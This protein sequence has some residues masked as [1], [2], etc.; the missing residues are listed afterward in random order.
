MY[1][2]SLNE[3]IQ[4]QSNFPTIHM[5]AKGFFKTKLIHL[6]EMNVKYEN[7]LEFVDMD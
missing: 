5:R 6:T 4:N 2:Y 7:E 3:T 1:T